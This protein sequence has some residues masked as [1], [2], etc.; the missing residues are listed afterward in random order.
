MYKIYI[1]NKTK[2]SSSSSAI[3]ITTITATSP[4]YISAPDSQSGMSSPKPPPA[5]HS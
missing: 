3:M 4:P 2:V 1:G 5:F